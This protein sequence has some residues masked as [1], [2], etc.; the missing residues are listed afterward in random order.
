MG[1]TLLDVEEPD[2]VP[3]LL[4]HRLGAEAELCA[5]ILFVFGVT[6]QLLLVL[7]AWSPSEGPNPGWGLS[8]GPTPGEGEEAETP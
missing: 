3:T 1:P 5:H 4:K 2:P 6:Q 7:Q 8:V